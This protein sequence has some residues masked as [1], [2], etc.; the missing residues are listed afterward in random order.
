MKEV[1]MYKSFDDKLFESKKDCLHYE[2][3]QNM[4][5]ELSKK[6]GEP[7][8]NP[9]E[10]KKHDHVTLKCVIDKFLDI[11]TNEI[12]RYYN[13]FSECKDGKRHISHAFRI[14]SE[15]TI[16]QGELLYRLNCININ[17]LY[18]YEQ[19]Y[20]AKNENEFKGQTI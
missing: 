19:P 5:I 16:L 4:F 7:I 10:R 8:S 9:E 3:V 12:P 18:E 1:T 17:S 14:A 15:S 11:C 13:I 6:L 2:Y 20:F